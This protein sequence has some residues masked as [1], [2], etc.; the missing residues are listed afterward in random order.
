MAQAEQ[1][2]D[3]IRFD[4]GALR[5]LSGR[6]SLVRFAAGAG[7]SRVAALV[8]QFAG[9]RP[10][11]PLLALPA[12]LV[13]SLTLVADD[14]GL[15]AAVDDSR[16]A[17]LGALGLVAFALVAAWQL[18]DR[19]TWQVLAL[20]TVAWAVVSGVLYGLQRLVLRG[21]DREQSPAPSG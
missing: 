1:D 19:P 13:A 11:G 6:E 16:G 17:V 14:D 5:K 21:R 8:S 7:A 10:A 12:I 4:P 20:A 9:S 3:R 15:R 18:G 2:D